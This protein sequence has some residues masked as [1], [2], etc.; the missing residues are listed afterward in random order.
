VSFISRADR[1]LLPW[2]P[3]ASFD[4]AG[5]TVEETPPAVVRLSPVLVRADW[6]IE[7]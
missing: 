3:V 2:H 4:V 7:H 1:D 6:A 5:P